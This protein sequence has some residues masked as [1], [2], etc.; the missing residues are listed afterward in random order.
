MRAVVFRGAGGPE[1]VSLADVPTPVPGPGELLVRV[2]ATAL[3]RADLLQRDGEYHV[4]KGQST[5]PGV[6][7]AGVVEALG[8]H[9]TG[10]KPG[11]R[12]FGVVEGGAFAEYCRLDAGMA[13]PVPA[14]WGFA[15]AAAT[16]ESWLTANETLFTLGGLTAGQSV[17]VHASASGVGAAMVQQAVRA[18]AV[19]YGT[20]SSPSKIDAV[21]A[22]GAKEVINHRAHEY[23][24]ELMRLTAGEGVDLVMDFLGGMALARNLSVL[25]RGGCVVAAGLLDGTED[26]SMNLLDVIERRLQIKGSSLRLRPIA[27]KREVN[28]RFRERWLARLLRDEVRPVIHTSYQ[29]EEINTALQEMEENRNIGKIVLWIRHTG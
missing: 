20:A 27:E 5:I 4:P 6:E 12:V 18:G 9:A 14:A 23:A 26:A 1:V 25:R 8:A 17:L 16:A 10:F 21:K 15:E 13:N 19:V 28:A 11:D 24:A 2:H 22:L 7:I 29:I 3:N